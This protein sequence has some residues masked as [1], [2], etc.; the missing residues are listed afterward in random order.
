[1]GRA[2]GDKGM[3]VGEGEGNGWGKKGSTRMV[4][5]GRGV[6]PPVEL[7]Q[8]AVLRVI[9]ALI[10]AALHRRCGDGGVHND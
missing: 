9:A 7:D 3:A 6:A 4:Q 2:V 10:T 1:M 5:T 8:L